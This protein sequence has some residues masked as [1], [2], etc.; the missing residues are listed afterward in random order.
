MYVRSV[1]ISFIL[2][3]TSSF[4]SQKARDPRFD[5]LSGNFK[6]DLF[7]TGYTFLAAA[8]TTELETLRKTAIAARKNPVLPDEE[9]EKIEAALTRME[10]REVSRKTKEREGEAMK[11]WKKDEAQ[12]REGGKKEFYLKKC[13]SLVLVA[14]CHVD[15]LMTWIVIS[16]SKGG[17][18]QG[19]V[20][21]AV[22]GQ[23]AV[24]QGGREEAADYGA[25]GQEAAAESALIGTCSFSCASNSYFP[26][27]QRDRRPWESSE[28]A[29]GPGVA[30]RGGSG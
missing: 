2:E 28:S 9:K 29:V 4:R 3:L 8:Q 27:R 5:S 12:K 16:G 6:P 24:A 21:C 17:A 19:Q 7:R 15:G 25:E 1:S 23:E 14:R 13:E 11:K 26:R 18:A 22:A 20:R 10:S 30:E